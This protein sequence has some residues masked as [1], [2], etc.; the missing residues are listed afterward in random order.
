MSAQRPPEEMRGLYWIAWWIVHGFCRVY[1]RLEARGLENVPLR[2]PVIFAAN[3]I[4]YLDPPLMGCVIPRVVNYMARHTL[5]TVP[6]FGA[7]IRKF[8]AVPVDRDSGAAGL[9]AILNKLTDGGAIILFPEGTRS[10][11]GRPLPAKPGVGMTILKSAAPVVP[12]KLIGSFEAL[13]RHQRFPRPRKIFV[14]FGPVEPFTAARA[15]AESCPRPRLKALYQ[16]VS[17]DIMRQVA[18]LETGSPGRGAK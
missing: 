3:H 14:C 17:D 1:F 10:M 15:E 13:G 2:G 4:S 5:F 8:N 16:E 11:D 7:V 18:A 6:I 9:R 12:V